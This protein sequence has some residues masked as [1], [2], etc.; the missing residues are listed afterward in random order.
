MLT[1]V[2]DISLRGQESHADLSVFSHAQFCFWN[3]KQQNK[4][5]QMILALERFGACAASVFTLVTMCQFVLCQCTRIV[6][7]LAADWT[8]N[9][10]SPTTCT[11][12]VGHHLA[13]RFTVTRHAG[14]ARW[15]SRSSTSMISAAARFHRARRLECFRSSMADWW[16]GISGWSVTCKFQSALGDGSM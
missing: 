1:V 7:Q 10:W 2:Q 4:D 15:G 3:S 14:V 9:Y 6:E 13:W 5:L 16:V 8:S 12:T 11:A